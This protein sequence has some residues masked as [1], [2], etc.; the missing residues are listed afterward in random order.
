MIR[1]VAPERRVK[2]SITVDAAFLRAVDKYVVAHPGTDR[3]KVV[4]EALRLWYAEQQDEAVAAYYHQPLS[5]EAHAEREAWR[6]IRAAAAERLFG[7][8]ED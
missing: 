3:S 1:A 2:V 8:S 4:D 7:G 6:Q 5:P